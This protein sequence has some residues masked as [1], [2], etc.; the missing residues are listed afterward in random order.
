MLKKETSVQHEIL[1]IIANRWSPRSFSAKEVTEKE[2]MTLLEAGR[3]AASCYNWQPWKIIYGLKGD[4]TFKRIFDC[5]VE[6]NQSWCKNAS[7]LMI[8]AYKKTNPDG[9]NNFHAL[10]DLGQ[11]MAN[12]S[13]QA[14]S[15]DIAIHQM[16]GV[17]V[18]KTMKEF[19]IPED[20][21]V[22]TA[23]AVGHYGDHIH[24]DEQLPKELKEQEIS[25]ERSRKPLKDF[26][27][28]GDFKAK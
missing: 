3:W 4:E 6:F 11:F 26:V 13:L 12:A 23:I 5:L 10:H 14:Q 17:N 21:H 24:A 27:F 18:E 9:K 8:G 2:L 19:G 25:P 1:P 15:M 22:A 28:N 20:Y 16:A 7:A